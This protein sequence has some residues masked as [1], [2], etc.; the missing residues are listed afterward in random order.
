MS[1]EFKI[2]NLTLFQFRGFREER[3]LAL[4]PRLNVFFGVNGSGK[5]TVLRALNVLLSSFISDLT[6]ITEFMEWTGP[7]DISDSGK[8]LRI[9]AE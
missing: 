9:Q 5:S 3:I 2:K 4:H 1:D 8:L 7:D 6:H